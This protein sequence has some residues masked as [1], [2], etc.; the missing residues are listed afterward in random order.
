MSVSKN[1]V[2]PHSF[3]PTDRNS[4]IKA[5][6]QPTTRR[7]GVGEKRREVIPIASSRTRISSV[8]FIVSPESVMAAWKG[9]R[10]AAAFR[11]VAREFP[12]QDDSA[13]VQI[14]YDEAVQSVSSGLLSITVDTPPP[15]L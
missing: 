2:V 8:F 11:R 12:R 4:M 3:S 9:T 13:V 15:R 10:G 14:A 6:I 7:P 1:I 5:H